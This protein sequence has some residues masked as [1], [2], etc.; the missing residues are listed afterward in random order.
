MIFNYNRYLKVLPVLA[1][2]FFL[3]FGYPKVNFAP[4]SW[5]SPYSPDVCHYNLICIIQPKTHR[6]PN[7]K[8]VYLSPTKH[9]QEFK[10]FDWLRK[11]PYTS[12]TGK[13]M[14]INKMKKI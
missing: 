5:R 14:K 6:N 2:Y 12:L 10:Y 4:V 9:T 3:Q 7:R 1:K 8:V 13:V 11:Y